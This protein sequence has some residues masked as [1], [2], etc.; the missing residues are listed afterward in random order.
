MATQYGVQMARLRTTSPVDL[1]TAAD[2]HGRVRC[3]NETVLLNSQRNSESIEVG[4][5]PKGARLLYGILGTSVSLG[6]ST[7]A[8]GV[9]GTPGKYRSA[10]TLTAVDT[11]ALFG[12]AANIGSALTA[13]E[14]VIA[15][16]GVADL[17]ASGTMRV[18]LFYMID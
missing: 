6:T 13:E 3:F 2:V 18:Q 11:P 8:V 10:A 4:R 5:L 17:P 16:I 15:T 9:T 1:P 7:I 12:V 14:I